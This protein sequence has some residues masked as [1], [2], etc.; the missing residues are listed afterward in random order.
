MEGKQKVTMRKRMGFSQRAFRRCDQISCVQ[1]A[2]C[3][4][5][6]KRTEYRALAMSVTPC[7]PV[8]QL[9]VSIAAPLL[10]RRFRHRFRDVTSL[11]SSGALRSA[12]F[13][14]PKHSR[15]SL[16]RVSKEQRLLSVPAAAA[17]HDGLAAAPRPMP[18]LEAAL[19]VPAAGLRRCASSRELSR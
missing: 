7:A 12:A 19:E 13:Q 6:A 5:R 2:K 16:G 15:R 9:S 8:L 14:Q 18:V 17:I 10:H 3:P 4:I 11:T 1:R